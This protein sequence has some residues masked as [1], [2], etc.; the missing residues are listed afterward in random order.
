MAASKDPSAYPV[1]FRLLLDHFEDPLA[2]SVETRYPD[3]AE[4]AR[5]RF[6]FY[7][8]KRALRLSGDTKACASAGAITV[9]LEGL[10][11]GSARLTF[12]ARD[13][14]DFAVNLEAAILQAK[15]AAHQPLPPSTPAAKEETSDETVQ[16]YLNP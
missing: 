3:L 1:A 13:N 11:D 5:V 6:T 12:S 15:G 9:A 7:N 10:A 2:H 8:Y 4:A 16:R 14:A